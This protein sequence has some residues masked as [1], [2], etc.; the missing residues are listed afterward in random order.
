M[1]ILSSRHL[2][3]PPEQWPAPA[4]RGVRTD[5]WTY[6]VTPAGP[7]LLFD[8]EADPFQLTNLAKDP[9][10]AEVRSAL[11]DEIVAW[12]ERAADPFVLPPS[13]WQ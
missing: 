7:W 11:A 2:R 4:F 6:A 3:W 8:N 1:H 9:A 5:R 13:A 10:E 12:L